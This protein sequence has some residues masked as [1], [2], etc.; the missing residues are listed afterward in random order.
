M[1]KKTNHNYTVGV[2]EVGRGPLA[3]P[4]TLC[5]LKVK[6]K[7]LSELKKVWKAEV[8]D[9]KKLTE[10]DREDIL[11]KLNILKK[12]GKI[13]YKTTSMNASLI[14]QKGI[15]VVIGQAINKC[16]QRLE[17]DP[18]KTEV[19]L[20]GLL[21]ASE[22]FKN[23]KTIVKGD[24]KEVVIAAASI[25]AKVKRDREMK[26][27]SKQY[28]KYGFEV[29]KGYG[30]KSHRDSINKNGLSKIHRKTYCKNLA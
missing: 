29:N 20:D 10:K 3:G 13:D 16:L 30:T 8:K 25:V 18:D 27:H 17:L 22:R 11:S 2:D 15:S 14:D 24:E 26:R 21:K 9:S 4:V 12:E 28:K 23:Q 7:D 5:A 19:K 6:N 1:S